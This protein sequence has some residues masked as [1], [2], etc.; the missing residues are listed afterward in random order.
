MVYSVRRVSLDSDK[1]A[2]GK[3]KLEVEGVETMK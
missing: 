1:G 3:V 2:L